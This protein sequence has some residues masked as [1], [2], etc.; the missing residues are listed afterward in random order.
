MKSSTSIG[1]LTILRVL[2]IVL[3]AYLFQGCS[4]PGGF[5]TNETQESIK[6]G[7]SPSSV[8]MSTPVQSTF[9]LTNTPK[10]T[11]SVVLPRDT[12]S[13]NCILENKRIIKDHVYDYYWSRNGQSIFFTIDRSKE[14]WFVYELAKQTT[15]KINEDELKLVEKWVQASRR[16]KDKVYYSSSGNY[17][18]F[19]KQSAISTQAPYE[20]PAIYEDVYLIQSG[21]SEPRF[22]G[23]LYGASES[24]FWS[25]D[26][27]V[28][29]IV[30][31]Q[32]MHYGKIST[33]HVYVADRNAME[34]S[35]AFPRKVTEGKVE[36]INVKSI[37]PDGN[38]IYYS[39]IDPS[40]DFLRKRNLTNDTVIE[41]PI[42]RNSKL[43][44][45][46]GRDFF[47]LF[48]QETKVEQI[49]V[50]YPDATITL[51]K[52]LPF[53]SNPYYIKAVS[54][55][56]DGQYLVFQDEDLQLEGLF[57]LTLCE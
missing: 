41:L 34:I 3:F 22:I 43:W 28:A 13:G 23:Q 57:M 8:P 15:R 50:Y 40:E 33:H 19:F 6:I 16:G 7:Q 44:P 4:R 55:S 56:P 14:T 21:S 46:N 48:E 26:E 39:E 10:P 18:I 35:P 20:Q 32:K 12:E 25:D 54:L 53:R 5:I 37:S 11:H 17:A 9:A 47:I 49:A 51:L 2:L 27:S 29:V 1:R 24:V 45:R 42:R 38:W 31:Q 30:M 36:V 52:H